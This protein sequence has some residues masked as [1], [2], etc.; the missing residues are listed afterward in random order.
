MGG[1]GG[2]FRTWDVKR[3]QKSRWLMAKQSLTNM[4]P[5]SFLAQVCEHSHLS[6]N[7]I[8]VIL[9]T[10]ERTTEVQ[11]KSC[12]MMQ[13][14]L[15]N[16]QQNVYPIPMIRMA[17]GWVRFWD[18]LDLAIDSIKCL[19]NSEVY[20]CACEVKNF[21]PPMPVNWRCGFLVLL[22]TPVCWHVKREKGLHPHTKSVV[23]FFH[24]VP[25]WHISRY[26]NCTRESQ[27]SLW[28]S[29][30]F[31]SIELR[32]FSRYPAL[33]RLKHF[34]I[35]CTLLFSMIFALQTF[36]KSCADKLGNP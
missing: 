28:I 6:M 30:V 16:F 18:I 25:Y 11:I 12:W 21:F 4:P 36:W 15:Q 22:Q 20:T 10:R 23:G 32:G 3:M 19:E 26:I 17:Q 8:C 27:R 29:G 1:C 33:P 5:A 31:Q 24:W 13:S 9:A 14:S 35:N 2:P 34:R 7:G